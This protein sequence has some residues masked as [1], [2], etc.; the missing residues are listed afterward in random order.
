MKILHLNEVLFSK[1]SSHFIFLELFSELEL[2]LQMVSVAWKQHWQGLS[3]CVNKLPPK[4]LL[5]SMCN[6]IIT[7]TN[8]LGKVA[9]RTLWWQTQS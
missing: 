3:V 1:A 6:L 9:W 4:R 7:S 8:P 2:N 5:L